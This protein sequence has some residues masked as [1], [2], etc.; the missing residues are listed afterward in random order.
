M[1]EKVLDNWKK[2]C[3]NNPDIRDAIKEGYE[4]AAYD[5][6]TEMI[7]AV[8]LLNGELKVKIIGEAYIIPKN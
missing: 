1:I 3:D 6:E 7:I 8:E 4:I 5:E 2:F